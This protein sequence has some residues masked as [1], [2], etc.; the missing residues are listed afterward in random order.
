MEIKFNK[1]NVTNTVTG[2]KARVF[3]SASVYTDGQ[4]GVTIYHK[5]YTDALADVFIDSDLYKNDTDSMTDY[6]E[7]GKVRINEDHALYP[8]AL[9]RAQANE[10]AAA[11]KRAA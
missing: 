5:D 7:T 11:A 8:A 6:F 9:A 2:K 1:F 4:V 3:Y 10:A